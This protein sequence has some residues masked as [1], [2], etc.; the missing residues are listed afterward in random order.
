MKLM[1]VKRGRALHW[2]T[3][4]SDVKNRF[5][6]KERS[7]I[8]IDAPLERDVFCAGQMYKLQD[9]PEGKTAADI[10]PIDFPPARRKVLDAI[11]AV[12]GETQTTAPKVDE[13]ISAPVEPAAPEKPKEPGPLVNVSEPDEPKAAPKGRSKK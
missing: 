9:A 7:I 2:P 13:T 6:C 10:T 4:I 3:D 11:D 5:R 1:Q 8:D 12:K